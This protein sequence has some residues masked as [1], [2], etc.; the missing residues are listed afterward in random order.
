MF[1]R[2]LLNNIILINIF[3]WYNN[4]IFISKRKWNFINCIW[5]VVL[6]ILKSFFN[7]FQSFGTNLFISVLIYLIISV[8]YFDSD[9][10]KRIVFIGFY[11]CSTFIS[12]INVYL[13][14]NYLTTKIS[15]INLDIWIYDLIGSILSALTLFCIIYL[16]TTLKNIKKLTDSKGI[17]YLIILPIISIM[18][19]TSIIYFKILT[20]NP[21]LVFLL[22][23]SIIIYNL[24]VCIGFADI[25]KSKNILIENE[26][27]KNQELHYKFLE[28]KFNNSRLFIHDFKKH[29][30]LI[31]EFIKNG[32]YKGINEYISE[33]YEEIKTDENLVITGNQLIDLII[34]TNKD[35]LKQYD[36]SIKHD[37]RIKN[38]DTIKTIDFN[39]V[40]SNLLDNAIE[41]CIKDGGHFIKIKLDIINDLIILK[42]IN[43]CNQY[44]QNIITTKS[45]K[46]YHG[47]GILNIK[48]ISYK[49]KGYT[50]FSY[51]NEY[52]IFTATVIFNAQNEKND[53]D[54]T[55]NNF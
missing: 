5:I 37:V 25:L 54:A 53:K 42:V 27:L 31:N 29:I 9:L 49:Y 43:P 35:T 40:F 39:I 22:T 19:I 13:L 14:L 50:K 7:I 30:N 47:L 8:V 11:I 21:I 46:D 12:E 24:I 36:I 17:W 23:S 44:D 48:R 16:I 26:Q 4:H 10:T 38:I 41:S 28:E 45:N 33:L 2:Y 3:L 6:L 51:D 20:I 52:N 32:D 55:H 15:L 34:N 18:I 1:F